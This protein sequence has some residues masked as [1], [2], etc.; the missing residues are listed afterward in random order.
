MKHN[1]CNITLFELEWY[2]AIEDKMITKKYRVTLEEAEKRYSE[3]KDAL[4]KDD[5]IALFKKDYYF[6]EDGELSSCT[7]VLHSSYG[8]QKVV[9][10]VK[11]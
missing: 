9:K 10:Y 3:M 5:K 4:S 2:L 7:E 1:V 6:A 8:T 11:L